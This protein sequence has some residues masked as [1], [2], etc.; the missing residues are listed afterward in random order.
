MLFLGLD[1]YIFDPLDEVTEKAD[2]KI[3]NLLKVRGMLKKAIKDD[4]SPM[5]HYVDGGPCI[6]EKDFKII[7]DK[8]LAK[9]L[10]LKSGFGT[11]SYDIDVEKSRE[12]NFLNVESI[13]L[14]CSEGD[15]VVIDIPSYLNSSY[16]KLTGSVGVIMFDSLKIIRKRFLADE[17][18]FS[19]EIL[20]LES[21]QGGNLDLTECEYRRFNI[22][23]CYLTNI[24]LGSSVR[25][26]MQLFSNSTVDY[27]DFSLVDFKKIRNIDEMFTYTYYRG[28]IDLSKLNPIETIRTFFYGHIDGDIKLGKLSS[29]KKM[30][31]S[32]TVLGTVYLKDLDLSDLHVSSFDD[33]F[34]YAHIKA[35][36][37]RGTSIDYV[38]FSGAEISTLYLSQETLFIIDKEGVTFNSVIENLV[39]TNV[40]KPSDCSKYRRSGFLSISQL[41]NITF[42][43]CSEEFILDTVGYITCASFNKLLVDKITI[44]GN[45]SESDKKKIVKGVKDFLTKENEEY[46]GKIISK[47]ARDTKTSVAEVER[48][49][50]SSK[51]NNVKDAINEMLSKEADS[52]VTYE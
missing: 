32:C 23:D 31:A 51:N 26:F 30:F 29:Y 37:L 22:Y 44:K 21:L 35:L 40:E 50:S 47:Y 43:D 6:V 28:S 4:I 18:E 39:F 14:R 49:Y 48:L 15:N 46:R 12:G 27:A 16:F 8:K 42:E 17:L 11:S 3:I 13:Q 5:R 10:L 19:H 38:A 2:D 41:E 36:D 24:K 52:L 34:L 1:N 7:L 45:N 20:C 25:S 33:M 9:A